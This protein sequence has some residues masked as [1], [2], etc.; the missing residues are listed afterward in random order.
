M[1]LKIELKPGEKCVVSGAVVANG[2]ARRCELVFENKVTILRE[3]EIMKPEDAN[4][5][6]K[7]LYFTIQL[8]YIDPDNLDRYFT[9]Y[10]SRVIEILQAAPSMTELINLITKLIKDQKYYK[11]LTQTKTLIELEKKLLEEAISASR[12]V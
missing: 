2:G 3:K 7:N 12:G 1:P 8:M 10:A 5:P 9:S 4:T 11:A 6:C